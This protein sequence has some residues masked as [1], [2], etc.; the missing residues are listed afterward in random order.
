MESVGPLSSKVDQLL[1][2]LRSKVGLGSLIEC[3]IVDLK[4]LMKCCFR[5]FDGIVLSYV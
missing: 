3:L 2:N 5:I 1:S 4:F